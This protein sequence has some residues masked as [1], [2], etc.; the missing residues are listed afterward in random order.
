M[1]GIDFRAVR[2]VAQMQEV[3]E[4]LQFTA[5]ESSDDQLRGPCPGAS[6]RL[7]PSHQTKHRIANKMF[8]VFGIGPIELLIVGFVALLIFGVPIIALVIL[9][10]WFTKQKRK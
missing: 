7:C 8:A 9:V 3:L 4:L 6:P 1:P 10:A 5:S 2:A